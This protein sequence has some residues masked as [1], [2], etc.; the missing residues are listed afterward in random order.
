MLV[1]SDEL[2]FPWEIVRPSGLVDGEYVELPPFGT[3][4]VF[5]RW[6]PATAARPQPQRLPIGRMALIIPDAKAAGLPWART[7]AQELRGMIPSAFCCD[8]TR[9]GLDDLLRATDVQLVHFSGHGS[10]GHNAD[11][12]A[13]VLDPPDTIPAMAFAASALGSR[14]HPMLFLNACSVGRSNRVLSRA[15]SFAG[16]CIEAGWSGVIAPYWPV[17]DPS[18][19]SFSVAFYRKLLSGCTIGEALQELRAENP[20]DPTA[21]SY[22]Y[23]GDPLARL[24]LQ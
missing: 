14:A 24:R 11:L 21:Q 16:N 3:A 1:F 12:T 9:A 4:H 2:A 6:R 7:E 8:A 5:G 17:Y 22:A 10:V 13:L 20:G 15:G 23:Y 18:A 19:A